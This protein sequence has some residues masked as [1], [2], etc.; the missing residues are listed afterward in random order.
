MNSFAFISLASCF[1]SLVL[2]AL[3]YAS[4]S[5]SKVNR[6]FALSCVILS[7]TAFAE[8]SLRQAPN[9]AEALVWARIDILWPLLM[10]AILHFTLA[11]T[12]QWKV[13]SKRRALILI[14]V[15][16]ACFTVLV[17]TTNYLTSEITQT[18]WGWANASRFN[19][20]TLIT[21]IWFISM[22]L[23]IGF[24]MWR[25]YIKQKDHIKKCLAKYIAIGYTIPS[26][27]GLLTGLITPL[28]GAQMPD[29]TVSAWAI[30]GLFIWYGIW[31]Y[32]LFTIDPTTAAESIFDTMSDLLF[33]VDM[34]GKIIRVNQAAL[35]VL[36]YREEEL[37]GRSL[38]PLIRETEITMTALQEMHIDEIDDIKDKRA[39]IESK[40]GRL[41]PVSISPSA[42]RDHKN[43]AVGFLFTARDMTERKQM[44][45][46]I[47]KLNTAIEQAN[48][49]IAIFNRSD[50]KITYA[51]PAFAQTLGY[52]SQEVT[53]RQYREFISKLNSDYYGSLGDILNDSQ[54]STKTVEVEHERKDGTLFPALLSLNYIRNENGVA[55]GVLAFSKDITESKMVNEQL[56]AQAKELEQMNVHLQEANRLKSIFLASMS[57]ELRTPLNSIIGF[58]GLI[59][60]GLTGD[61]TDEQRNQLSM[62]K[63]SAHHL[64]SLIN[65][66]LDLSKLEAGKFQLVI[67]EVNLD[68]LIKDTLNTISPLIEAK[69]LPINSDIEQGISLYSDERRIKQILINLL[70]NAIKFTREGSIFL[71]AKLTDNSILKLSVKDTGMGISDENLQKL[72]K[73]FSQVKDQI[74]KNIDGTGLGLYLSKKL[75]NLMGGD[76][77][78]T[79]ELGKGSDFVCTIPLD[80]RKEDYGE[81]HTDS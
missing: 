41:I 81:K 25:Y 43:K 66:I 60:N 40:S 63:S 72:F 47:R 13:L 51:N 15:P 38:R 22:V 42:L 44:E 68:D 52:D 39:T 55:D 65:D 53:G 17:I 80:I 56:I 46:E 20:A 73:P 75:A 21:N 3:V 10:V 11:F 8:Y 79:S 36:D 77:S 34:N 12:E 5:K 35:S 24:I 1:I 28:L 64:L 6:L 67:D 7:Y 16:A 76:I 27:T 59:L 58:T 14:Y 54:I 33:L 78:A 2:A 26:L 18:W 4:N 69:Q 71:S 29:M 57:H 9:A 45:D 32:R 49:G 61:I 31:K 19:A 70:G 23:L 48:D 74:T 50:R 62:V 37:V 30:G